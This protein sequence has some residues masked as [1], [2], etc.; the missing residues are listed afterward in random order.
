[1]LT[2]DKSRHQNPL[3]ML[4]I[5]ILYKIAFFLLTHLHT[6]YY[7]DPMTQEDFARL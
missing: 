6:S 3:D 2:S 5:L 4:M 1:M 7:G